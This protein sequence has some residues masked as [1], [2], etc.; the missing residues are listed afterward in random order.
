MIHFQTN[1]H[2]GSQ[3]S[4]LPVYFQALIYYDSILSNF[5]LLFQYL[6]FIYK[7]NILY[8]ESGTIAG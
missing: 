5:A 8:Y 7:Y 2:K 3:Q 6:L 1:E 4:L